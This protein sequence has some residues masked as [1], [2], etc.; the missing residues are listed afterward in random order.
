[1]LKVD[2]PTDIICNLRAVTSATEGK[3]IPST[4]IAV[5]EIMDDYKFIMLYED[6]SY[7]GRPWGYFS[8]YN[9]E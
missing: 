9:T 3:D 5:Y 7:A 6:D 1:M 4:C 2:E 8:R